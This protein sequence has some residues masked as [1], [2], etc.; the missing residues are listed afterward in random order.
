MGTRIERIWRMSADFSAL[1]LTRIKFVTL[2]N[3][4][5]SKA[6]KSALIRQIRSIR[7]PIN[8]TRGKIRVQSLQS[9]FL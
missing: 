5:N 4:V 6:E 9:V 2:K 8:S 1:E 3:Q 7:V